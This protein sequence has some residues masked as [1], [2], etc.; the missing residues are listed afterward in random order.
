MYYIHTV[1]LENCPYSTSAKNLLDKY[2][3]KYTNIIVNQS[4]KDKFKTGTLQTFPQVF[5]KKKNSKGSLYLGGYNEMD[6]LCRMFYKQ[7][8]NSSNLLLVQN[9]YKISKKAGLRLIE[10]INNY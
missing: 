5:L 3:I 7:P 2:N 10:L 6:E 4:N 9:K 8:L 1:L